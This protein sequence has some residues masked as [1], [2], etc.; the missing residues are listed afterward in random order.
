[1]DIYYIVNYDYFENRDGPIFRMTVRSVDDYKRYIVDIQDKRIFPCFYIHETDLDDFITICKET[2]V[3]DLILSYDKVDLI[4]EYGDPVVKI[5]T[6]YPRHVKSIRDIVE[7]IIMTFQADVKYE[8]K[9]AQ[10]LHFRTFLEIDEISKYGFTPLDSIRPIK[11]DVEYKV[12]FNIC[13]WDIETDGRG[14]KGKQFSDCRFAHKIPIISYVTYN[15]FE[16]KFTYY[17]WRD[18]WEDEVYEI[19][20]ATQLGEKALSMPIFDNYPHEFPCTVKK[21][22]KE[23]DMHRTF[24]DDFQKAKYDGIVTFN[25]RGGNR[26]INKNGTQRRVWYTGFDM[27]MFI[28]RCKHMKLHMDL[29]KLSIIPPVIDRFGKIRESSIKT[30]I[31]TDNFGNERAREYR[32][33]C[34]PQH[35]FMYDSLLL[36]YSDTH[37]KMKRKNLDTYL[38]YFLG[39]GKVEHEGSSVYDMHINEWEKEMRY[40]IVDVEGLY[41]LDK[42]FMYVQDVSMRA[43][44]YGGKI[45]DGV[46]AS[47]LHDHIK[48]W[49]TE[50]KYVL[51]TRYY[52]D[53]VFTQNKWKGMID[54][55]SGGFNLPVVKIVHGYSTTAFIVILDFSKLYPSCLRTLNADTRTKVELRTIRIRDDGVFLV[56][57]HD[58]EFNYNDLT[59]CPSGWFRKDIDAID[60]I[61]F[62]DLIE[63]RDEYS[64][65]AANYKQNEQDAVDKKIKVYYIDMY[66]LYW[67]I[68]FSLKGLINGKFGT[69]GMKSMRS[70]DYVVYNAAAATG[71]IMIQKTMSILKE[72]GYEPFFASTDSA[73]IILNEKDDKFKAWNEAMDLV[74]ILND[75]LDVYQREEFNI[76]KNYNKIGCEKLANIAIM[77]D[78][79]RYILSTIMME[80]GGKPIELK[81]PYI[82]V[83]GLE[84]VRRDS[85]DITYDIQME[86][87]EK[88]VYRESKEKIFEWLRKIDDEF[89]SMPWNYVCQKAGISM[90]VDEG[91]GI[92]YEACRN[93]NKYFGKHYDSGSTPY[94]GKFASKCYPLTIDGV[95]VTSN[96]PDGSFV[97]AFGEN[98]QWEMQKL[99][100]KLDYG[101]MKEKNLIKK[102]EPFLELVFGV[103]Y[104]RIKSDPGTMLEF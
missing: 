70:F 47:R 74:N 15:K 79:R 92:K 68:Q 103:K 10:Q 54:G 31:K 65:I 88:I 44:R 89:E 21:F 90:G 42:Y 37:Y 101:E 30:H 6:K 64:V 49:Y 17:G 55:K 83:K 9:V 57:D 25:G 46:Y 73:M 53:N 87:I 48:L 36:K 52:G 100:F 69:T 67:S 82:Y 50:G 40:N 19:T 86:L 72:L 95:P 43:L 60:T 71:Q 62:N 20:H 80:E 1:M 28:E 33:K 96:R 75:K 93:A 41:A 77:F 35:D 97:C 4:S 22:K 23:I 91:S 26:I 99:G 24:L 58:R 14:V 3:Y 98:D 102:I 56:D 29:E 51:P 13:Y 66:K 7:D 38:N 81:E 12:E 59:R 61:I 45:E 85:A 8:K 76:D 18:D 2:R 84:L 11:P 32:I 16:Q 34:L 5:T 39:F 27:P 104:D 94:L 63:D 78:K